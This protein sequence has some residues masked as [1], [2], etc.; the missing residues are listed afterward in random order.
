MSAEETEM[1]VEESAVEESVVEETVAEE[2]A[3][4]ETVVEE[5]AVMTMADYFSYYFFS[6]SYNIDL[7]KSI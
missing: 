6:S 4:E 1:I 2:S 3:V 5:N 7:I